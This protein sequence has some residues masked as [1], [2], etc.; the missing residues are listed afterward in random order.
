M[1]LKTMGTEH[2]LFGFSDAAG[3]NLNKLSKW[4]YREVDSAIC[5]SNACKENFCLRVKIDPSNVF[6]IPNAVD[7]LRFFPDFS[8]REKEPRG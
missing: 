6:T 5:V 2:S 8:I 7:S 1:G 3:I 4:T